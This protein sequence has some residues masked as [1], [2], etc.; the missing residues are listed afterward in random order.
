MD[1]GAW[2]SLSIGVQRVGHSWVTTTTTT[3]ERLTSL[4]E[5]PPAL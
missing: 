3:T 5:V 2:W 4:G 1:G